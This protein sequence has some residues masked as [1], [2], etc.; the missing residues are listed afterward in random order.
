MLIL[1]LILFTIYGSYHLTRKW[2]A[3]STGPGKGTSLDKDIIWCIDYQNWST[4][5]TCARD[6]RKRK[7]RRKPYCGK[8]G[9]HP[10][11]PR[12][13]SKCNLARL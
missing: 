7:D 11:H 13:R 8:L 10:D 4:S 6:R 3:V 9:I 2:W 1:T 12:G 5:E